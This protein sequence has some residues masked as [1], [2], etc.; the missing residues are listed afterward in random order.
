[1]N[2]QELAQLL[3]GH[4]YR[5]YIQQKLLNEA[6]KYNLIIVYGYSD[7]IIV[8]R[9]AVRTEADCFC[10]GTLK[11][12]RYGFLGTKECA[13][14]NGYDDCVKHYMRSQKCCNIKAILCAENEPSWT[15]KLLDKELDPMPDSYFSTF[16]ILIRDEVYCRGLVFSLDEIGL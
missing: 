10:G 11:F 13:E 16:N 14:E 12:D 5:E 15:Y 2:A 6:K 9:G 4:Q 1:M 8:F 7:D 3:N